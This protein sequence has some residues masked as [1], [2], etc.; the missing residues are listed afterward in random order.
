M[1][2]MNHHAARTMKANLTISLAHCQESSAFWPL[3]RASI[4]FSQRH[5][6]VRKCANAARLLPHIQRS[7]P[8]YHP[9]D[10]QLTPALMMHKRPLGEYR[11]APLKWRGK[12]G[13][14]RRIPGKTAFCDL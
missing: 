6:A 14:T 1:S 13:S 4:F 8:G 10:R 7:K 9:G 11:E 12:Y 3:A 2:L 5:R